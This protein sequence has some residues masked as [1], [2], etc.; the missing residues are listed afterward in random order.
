ML[1][2]IQYS[3]KKNNDIY[4][5]IVVLFIIAIIIYFA[6]NK[7]TNNDIITIDVNDNIFI[8]KTIIEKN[9]INYNK[10][11]I[12]MLNIEALDEVMYKYNKK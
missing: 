6:L 8:E 9:Q 11:K 3:I 12:I 1:S 4:K 2:N 10:H 7:K 5:V